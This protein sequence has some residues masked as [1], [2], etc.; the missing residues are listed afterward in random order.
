MAIKG[1]NLKS[2]IVAGFV[3]GWM[4]YLMDR[5]FAGCLGLFGIYPGTSDWG[6]MFTHHV[7]SIIFAI[8]FAWPAI[9]KKLPGSGWLKGLVYGLLWWIII[10]LIL[11]YIGALIGATVIKEMQPTTAEMFISVMLLRL[12][13]GLIIG[14][15]YVPAKEEA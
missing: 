13:W 4:M 10:N 5:Y 6:W 14:T 1:V 2:L 11:G 8:P 3:A 9:Y 12:S 15:L 7:E